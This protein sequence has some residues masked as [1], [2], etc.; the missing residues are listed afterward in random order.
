V[1]HGRKI[2]G[3]LNMSFKLEMG[4]N[5]CSNAA[6]HSDKSFLSSSSFKTLLESP[7]KF[8]REHI[9]GEKKEESRGDHFIEGSLMHT[10]I[11][12]PHLVTKEYAVYEGLRKQGTLW[13]EFLKNLEPGK[14]AVSRAQMERAKALQRAYNANP[15]ARQLLEGAEF[16]YTMCTTYMGIPVKVRADAIQ[17]QARA[18]S[19]CKSTAFGADEAGAKQ[20]VS[21]WNYGLSAAMYADVAQILYPGEPFD[22]YWS[23]ISKSELECQVYKMS[24]AT[25]EK[26]R[27]Q[28]AKAAEVYHTCMATGLWPEGQLQKAK[29]TYDVKEI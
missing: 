17:L 22:F 9:L 10:L 12:E 14:A 8:H 25:R 28:L 13:D 1:S 4:L 24:E 26:G 27:A 15:I 21:R 18:I 16:E 19:D 23:F 29:P 2:E 5:K 6:Y 3:R 20:A 7:A 11:L